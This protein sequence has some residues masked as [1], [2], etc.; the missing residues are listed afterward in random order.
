MEQLSEL[1]QSFCPLLGI[2]LNLDGY[3]RPFLTENEIYL[4][5]TFTPIEHLKTVDECLT[6]QISSDT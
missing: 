1:I 4:V 3:D 2:T 5:V 6:D